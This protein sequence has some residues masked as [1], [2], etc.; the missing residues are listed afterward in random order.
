MSDGALK[1]VHALIW[2]AI[3]EKG[4][5]LLGDWLGRLINFHGFIAVRLIQVAQYPVHCSFKI[6]VALSEGPLCLLLCE[7]HAG[8]HHDRLRVGS[9]LT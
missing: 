5:N 6:A 1:P 9:R 8:H 3:L 4:L 2:L 7:A